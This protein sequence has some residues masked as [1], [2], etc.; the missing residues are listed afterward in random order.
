M[1]LQQSTVCVCVCV[2][3]CM[4]IMCAYA[5]VYVYVCMCMCMCGCV[6]VGGHMP[7]VLVCIII[8]VDT[9]ALIDSLEMPILHVWHSTV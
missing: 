5:C 2:C 8:H 6:D 4:F 7:H 1:Q 3:V 9:V